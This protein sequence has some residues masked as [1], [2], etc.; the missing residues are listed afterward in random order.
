MGDRT[1]GILTIAT[2]VGFYFLAKILSELINN[3]FK[4]D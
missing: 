2:I 4:K 3:I 1:A